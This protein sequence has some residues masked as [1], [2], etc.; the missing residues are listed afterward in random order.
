MFICY[1]TRNERG[2]IEFWAFPG[3]IPSDEIP[4]QTDGDR[5]V[6]AEDGHTWL[7]ESR[8]EMEDF[9]E[10]GRIAGHGASIRTYSAPGSHEQVASLRNELTAGKRMSMKELGRRIV[11]IGRKAPTADEVLLDSYIRH[12]AMEEKLRG[13]HDGKLFNTAVTIRGTKETAEAGLG[14]HLIFGVQDPPKIRKADGKKWL[15]SDTLEIEVLGEEKLFGMKEVEA[16]IERHG[17][18]SCK[19]MATDPS[20]DKK[21]FAYDDSDDT[22]ARLASEMAGRYLDN[23]LILHEPWGVQH[24]LD[25][26]SIFIVRLSRENDADDGKTGEGPIIFS[27]TADEK[28]EKAALDFL[29]E[30]CISGYDHYMG[31]IIY[32]ANRSSG[33]R[34]ADTIRRQL[35]LHLE[36]DDKV[37][38]FCVTDASGL[39][40]DELQELRME[41]AMD[42]L[43]QGQW[44]AM[45]SW[46]KAPEESRKH[47]VLRAD[48]SRGF[49]KD[50]LDD[51]PFIPGMG[52]TAADA[53]KVLAYM[54]LT[55]AQASMDGG[56]QLFFIPRTS[57][58]KEWLEFNDEPNEKVDILAAGKSLENV[59]RMIANHELHILVLPGTQADSFSPE[60]FGE[61]GF[62]VLHGEDETTWL[63][64][65]QQMHGD[66]IQSSFTSRQDKKLKEGEG[67]AAASGRNR[68]PSIIDAKDVLW[69]DAPIAAE[70]AD[71]LGSRLGIS[72]HKTEDTVLSIPPDSPLIGMFSEY[73]D[74]GADGWHISAGSGIPLS[75][76]HAEVLGKLFE[77][78]VAGILELRRLSSCGQPDVSIDWNGKEHRPGRMEDPIRFVTSFEAD[79]MIKDDMK[80]GESIASLISDGRLRCGFIQRPDLGIRVDMLSAPVDMFFDDLEYLAETPDI[81]MM[82]AV[83]Q[84]PSRSAFK[85]MMTGLERLELRADAVETLDAVLASQGL[86][87]PPLPPIDHPIEVTAPK[88]TVYAL[89][90]DIVLLPNGKKP[91]K[92]YV[93]IWSADMSGK[94]K[95]VLDSIP[96][97]LS[98]RLSALLMM[99]RSDGKVLEVIE[100]TQKE[101]RKKGASGGS[102]TQGGTRSVKTV[103]L[104]REFRHRV[105]QEKTDH[106]PVPRS[107]D[108]KVLTDVNVRKHMRLQACGPGWKDHKLIVIES[109]AKRMFVNPGTPVTKI[110][111]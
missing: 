101:A 36:G 48:F 81:L 72:S 47:A 15:E 29:P 11:D 56:C 45:K 85:K 6:I 89:V 88:G 87:I 104:T 8:F 31:L 39:D 46:L 28:W 86:E 103:S 69:N 44:K 95:A 4:V 79:D 92:A 68:Q 64:M 71:I 82:R 53:A 30:T 2:G 97:E 43:T 21:V 54:M 78:H 94:Y 102:G 25:A 73:G 1:R 37:L 107:T 7:V 96:E 109:Y 19:M 42:S 76:S 61:K 9:Q 105:M 41:A 33:K 26:K 32:S 20:F 84:N 57:P 65:F 90:E 5:E 40:R 52:T 14:E 12:F 60:R 100:S 108:G 93:S 55:R 58:S 80:P 22:V 23:D 38:P 74:S 50:V 17:K 75:E 70:G 106:V 110:I 63:G 49:F 99:M 34:V 27:G 111:R 98:R 24:A 59:I 77:D 10:L 62:A 67:N 13:R 83:G 51:A 35:T 3:D 18:D 16:Y 66:I 91:P